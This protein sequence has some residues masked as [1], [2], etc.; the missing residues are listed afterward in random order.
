[1]L[2]RYRFARGAGYSILSSLAFSCFYRRPPDIQR[3][4]DEGHARFTEFQKKLDEERS[5]SGR[6]IH[7]ARPRWAGAE[8]YVLDSCAGVLSYD[9]GLFVGAIGRWGITMAK[10]ITRSR[11]WTK[12]D[13]RTLKSLA[14]EKTK[15]TVI[16]R[17]LIRRA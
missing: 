17:N 2:L 11:P 4:L 16:A 9:R 14:R 15:T 8:K 10:K 7:F 6:K 12:E 3:Q 1:M 5:Q 13:V